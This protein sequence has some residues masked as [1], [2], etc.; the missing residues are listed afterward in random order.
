MKTPSFAV[1][2]FYKDG[3]VFPVQMN[4]LTRT[5]ADIAREWMKIGQGERDDWRVI[6][7]TELRDLQ[8]A[9]KVTLSCFTPEAQAEKRALIES[10]TV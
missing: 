4:I 8:R 10:A 2:E 9:G 3:T 7:M 5:R 1:A 6:T